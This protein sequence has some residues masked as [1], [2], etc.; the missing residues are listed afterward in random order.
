MSEPCGD[1][2]GSYDLGCIKMKY[3]GAFYTTSGTKMLGPSLMHTWLGIK[4]ADLHL[5][6]DSAVNGVLPWLAAWPHRAD[7]LGG[8]SGAQDSSK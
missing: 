4:A 6:R 5:R 8:P 3:G 1:F 2:D 7:R